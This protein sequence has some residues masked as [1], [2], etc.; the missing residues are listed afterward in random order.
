MIKYGI[1][2]REKYGLEYVKPNVPITDS[3]GE[4]LIL[5]NSFDPS[6]KAPGG[7]CKPFVLPS[8]KDGPLD[9]LVLCTDRTARISR[10]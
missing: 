2:Y 9:L 8:E 1:A 4:R 7:N 10:R 5:G 6:V 3:N